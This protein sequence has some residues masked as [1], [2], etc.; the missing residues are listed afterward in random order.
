M[1]YLIC[2]F[3]MNTWYFVGSDVCLTYLYCMLMM[4]LVFGILDS[5]VQYLKVVSEAFIQCVWPA[6]RSDAYLQHLESGFSVHLSERVQSLAASLSDRQQKLGI[7]TPG[8]WSIW[9]RWVRGCCSQCV[10]HCQGH[11]SLWQSLSSL[12]DPATD[13]WRLTSAP[14]RHILIINCHAHWHTC[15]T[16]Q[17]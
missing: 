13:I 1:C 4:V 12:S 6:I 14:L 7:N 10:T 2:H 9:P 16:N 11:C 15:R 17:M 3:E 5:N 8:S